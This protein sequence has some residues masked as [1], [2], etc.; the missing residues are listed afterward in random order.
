[1]AQALSDHVAA[2]KTRTALTR[3]PLN[4]DN[5]QPR[6]SR[7]LGDHHFDFGYPETDLPESTEAETDSQTQISVFWD[8]I[9]VPS[10]T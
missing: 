7:L 3:P 9:I 1:M 4:R 8:S 5:R 10:K 2:T 6:L